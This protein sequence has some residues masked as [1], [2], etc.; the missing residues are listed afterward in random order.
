VD[1]G[2]AQRLPNSEVIRLATTRDG[3]VW[4]SAFGFVSRWKGHTLTNYAT[5]S[6][7]V[8]YAVVEDNDGTF[9]FGQA[10]PSEGTGPI[11]Q[12]WDPGLRCLGPLDG[13]P[14]SN[15]K[16]ILADRDGTL[17]FGGDTLLL[18]W[19][20]GGLAGNTGIVGSYG[21]RAVTGRRVVGGHR[22]GRPR[23]WPAAID[24]RWLS[25]DTPAFHG[26]SVEV[27]ALYADRE[28]SLWVGT[29]DHGI[30]RIHGSVVDHIGRTNGLSGDL[31]HD[32]PRIAKGTFGW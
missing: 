3:S 5:G 28:G 7:G 25:F 29:Y 8:P 4:I 18:H 13:I 31:V 16:A 20:Q 1:A 2:H 32:T 23:P 9:W 26:S 30:Y 12:V 19:A 11:C 22:E 6:R 27:T 24:R 14:S 17:S 15:A 10:I 21:N